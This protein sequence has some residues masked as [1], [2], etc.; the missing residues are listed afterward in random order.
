MCGRFLNTHP[1]RE[2]AR[3]FRAMMDQLAF[4]SF[5]TWNIAPSQPIRAVRVGE[6][7]RVLT[8]LQWGF[9]PF[10]AK[11]LDD[12]QKPI[13][14]RGETVATSGMF[15]AA[16]AKRRCVIPASGFYEWQKVEGRRTKQPFAILPTGED[17]MFAF[18]GVWDRWGGGDELDTCAIITTTPNEVMKPIHDRMPVILSRDAVDEWLAEDAEPDRLRALLAP[19]DPALLRAYPVSRRVN[20]PKHDDPDCIK[21]EMP[22]TQGDLF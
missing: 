10:W 5:A 17:G 3:A 13:N 2:I 15:R 16:F 20:S 9:V 12:A 14:A 8:A 18:A 6:E 22:E 11:S 21:P 4:E 7:G 19:C 1:S